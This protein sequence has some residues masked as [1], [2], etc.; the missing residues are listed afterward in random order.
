MITHRLKAQVLDKA[1]SIQLELQIR[2]VVSQLSKDL[3][4]YI[5]S[6]SEDEALE[7]ATKGLYKYAQNLEVKVYSDIVNERRSQTVTWIDYLRNARAFNSKDP[8]SFV[9]KINPNSF[10]RREITISKDSVSVEIF[11]TETTANETIPMSMFFSGRI[12]KNESANY[13]YFTRLKI[14]GSKRIEAPADAISFSPNTINP[15][16]TFE[17]EQ[18]LSTI[19]QKIG[20][21]IANKMP[22]TV[23]KINLK[24]FSLSDCG[25]FD[26]FA[27][28]VNVSLAS[29]I[30]FN[31]KNALVGS[32]LLENNE[33]VYQIEGDYRIDGEY[34]SFNVKMVDPSGKEIGSFSNKTLPLRWFTANKTSFIP[35]EFEPTMADKK[36]IEQNMV[37]DKLGLAI[38]V[39]TNKGKDNLM[40]KQGD[41]VEVFIK[42]NKPCDVRIL[43]RQADGLLTLLGEVKIDKNQTNRSISLGSSPCIP[44]F[45]RESLIVYA[46]NERFG[47]LNI[48][49]RKVQNSSQTESYEIDVITNSLEEACK[50]TSGRGLGKLSPTPNSVASDNIAIFTTEK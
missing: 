10:K 8:L 29:E 6:T 19:I 38:E 37:S 36:V 13:G 45:G 41:L 3:S 47:T 20:Q 22:S 27:R 49:K 32:Y 7:Q 2:Q 39:T 23:K 33:E 14:N 31:I 12:R 9:L 25:I 48:E 4:A 50:I 26:T 40:F 35:A 11:F 43:Y 1:S 28:E 16:T 21:Q 5:E 44:P 18:S 30:K 46:S 24:R 42:V 34:L 17:D 15:H